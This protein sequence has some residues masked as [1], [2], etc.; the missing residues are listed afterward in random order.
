[1]SAAASGP[2]APPPQPAA[3]FEEATGQPAT[4]AGSRD[5]GGDTRAGSKMSKV[6]QESETRRGSLSSVG[7]LAS[8]G[9]IMQR[10]EQKISS[11]ATT[12]ALGLGLGSRARHPP[13]GAQPARRPAPHGAE[14]SHRPGAVPLRA[15]IA[16]AFAGTA[17][18]SCAAM[19][20]V[21]EAAAAQADA[22]DG[23]PGPSWAA[24]R[25]SAWLISFAA[26]AVSL[27]LGLALSSAVVRPMDDV[28]RLVEL[29]NEPDLARRAG[30]LRKLRGTRRSWIRDVGELQETCLR[31]SRG[32][33]M[34]MRYVPDTV[35]RGIVRGEESA[36]R[37]HVVRRKVTIMFSDIKDFTAISESLSQEDLLYVLTRYLSIMTKV[38]EA[39][40]GVVAEILGDGLLAYW[41]AP[42][43]VPG[44]ETKACAAA[45]AQQQVL[46][47]LNAE[48]AGLGLPSLS[49][50]IGL[51]TGPVLSGT[52]GS[53]TKMKFGCLG[54]PVNLA[55]RLEGLCK[56]YGVS[57]LC[58][59]QTYDGLAPDSGFLCR[60][61]DLVLVKGRRSATRIYEVVGVANCEA[62]LERGGRVRSAARSALRESTEALR[63]SD[64][65][66]VNH[67]QRQRGQFFKLGSYDLQELAEA[68]ALRGTP[69]D[70]PGSRRASPSPP[71]DAGSASVL[72]DEVTPEAR[73]HVELYER[74]LR[75]YQQAHFAEAQTLLRAFLDQLPE[76]RAAAVLLERVNQYVSTD[77]D[78]TG[79]LTE[80][81]LG[82]WTGVTSIDEK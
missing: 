3:C 45:M 51:H 21:L 65:L 15:L 48:L 29:L 58:S 57:V 20:V 38:L 81:E 24:V 27:A 31:L 18:A 72:W 62:C 42:E 44:H 75:E 7:S 67:I 47:P 61:L 39:Y 32:V 71:L 30:E 40:Q 74:A 52:M 43:D 11:S 12:E 17:A 23:V 69:P 56:V 82:A 5:S 64:V 13:T 26:V 25:A 41:N 36:M 19:L 28:A 46:R 53:E 60:Q 1:M 6:S 50:R 66:P 4:G 80:A 54:D 22:G 34:F 37:L 68:T 73:R 2:W 63:R 9:S 70:L 16:A 55:S 14:A 33:E 79:L 8:H 59:G 76:D 78:G 35:V 77:C 10:V 49:V